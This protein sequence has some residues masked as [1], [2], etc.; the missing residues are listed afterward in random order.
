M[1]YFRVD[2]FIDELMKTE[3]A[4]KESS[5]H[6]KDK[7]VTIGKTERDYAIGKVFLKIPQ[8]EIMQTKKRV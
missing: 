5:S 4:R 3:G 8:L 6:L 2:K 7:E 1:D